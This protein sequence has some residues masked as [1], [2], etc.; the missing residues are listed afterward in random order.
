MPPPLRPYVSLDGEIVPARERDIDRD[1]SEIGGYLVIA[2]E[3]HAWHAIAGVLA[4]LETDRPQAFDRIM[5]GC[6]D[7]SDS[8]PEVDGLDD[9]LAVD[10]QMLFDVSSERE[11]RRDAQGYVAGADARAFLQ[12]AR[13]VD[14]RCGTAAGPA[15]SPLLNEVL[16]VSGPGPRLTHMRAQLLFLQEHAVDAYGERQ[17]ELAYLGNALLAG[18]SVQSRSFAAAEASQ[19]ALAICNLGLDNWPATLPEDLLAHQG[20]VRVFEVGFTVLHERVCMAAAEQLIALIPSLPC[21]DPETQ[22]ALDALRVT[23]TREWRAGTPWQARDAMDVLAILDMP[24][25]AGLLGLVAECPVLPA[26][27]AASLRP[28]AR[29]VSA[30]A[31]DFI[32]ENRQIA[33]VDAFLGSLSIRFG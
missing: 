18:C 24:S 17:R 9:L 6:R 15:A 4:A 20:L 13:R 30:T 16:A 7:L 29:Q 27:V 31:F 12:T 26:A 8:R 5:A 23:L 25:W 21:A 3:T 19:A 22:A 32:S 14:L 28:P 1:Q 10:D 2:R 11:S 33:A